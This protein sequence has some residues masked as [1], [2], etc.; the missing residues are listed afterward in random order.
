VILELGAN[1]ALRGIPLAETEKALGAILARLKQRRLEVLLAG[2]EAPRNW[3]ETYVAQFRQ[4]Y[5][6]L[7]DEH[8]AKLYP[9]FLDGVALDA[10]LSLNDGMHPNAEGVARVVE[11]ILPDVETLIERVKAKPTRKVERRSGRQQVDSKEGG[12]YDLSALVELASHRARGMRH[13]FA[14]AGSA[15]PIEGFPAWRRRAAGEFCSC[16]MTLN[17]KI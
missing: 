10:S 1:D 6:S 15:V 12:S 14:P 8:G 2:M 5:R 11:R 9:F 16:A 17:G 7:A 4:M 13:I 3:G